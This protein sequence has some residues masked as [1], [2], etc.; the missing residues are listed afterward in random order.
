MVLQMIS[1]IPA[2]L[3]I[4]GSSSPLNVGTLFRNAVCSDCRIKPRLIIMVWN[5]ERSMAHSLTSMAAVT[6]AVLLQ[7]YNIA[8]SPK[9][10]PIDEE[11]MV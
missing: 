11:I 6:V 10:F 7:L 2:I 5:L 3:T 9:T 4:V 8:S 1:F